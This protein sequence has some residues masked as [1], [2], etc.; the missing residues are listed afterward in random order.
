MTS[1]IRGSAAPFA[2]VHELLRVDAPAVATNIEQAI[3]RAVR[4]QLFRHGAVVAVSG[5]VDSALVLHLCVRALGAERVLGLF[6]PER[7]SSPK[8]LEFS[9]RLAR[10]LGIRSVVEDITE[11]LEA[12]GCYERRDAAIRSLIPEYG[13]GCT[14]KIV[15]DSL[16]ARPSPQPFSVVVTFPDG[17][18]TRVRATD[19]ALR[20][21]VS[22]TN[23]KQRARK[24]MEYYQADLHRYA[25]VGTPNRLEY[26]LGFFVK[27]GDGAADLKPIAHLYK[28]QVFELSRHVGVFEDILRQPPSTD[29]YPGDQTQEE[30]FFALPLE[31][32]DLCL[33]CANER[34]DTERTANLTGLTPRQVRAVYADID[35]KR[36]LAGYLHAQPQM[37]LPGSHG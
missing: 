36:A 30:F 22:A 3:E 17:S 25:V 24:S 13:S 35:A 16:L 5:G 27:N 28:S 19:Q 37:M 6:L 9:Q 2:R 31:V 23:F 33:F 8:A 12:T 4:R 7:E 18:E 34:F 10:E 20:Q 14:C 29:T 15:T 32:L 1:D 26:E 21:I 11:V